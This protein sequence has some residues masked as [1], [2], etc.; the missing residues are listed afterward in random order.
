MTTGPCW[1][2]YS[3]H[4]DTNGYVRVS[5][6]FLKIENDLIPVKEQIYDY[7]IKSN[8]RVLKNPFSINGLYQLI[9]KALVPFACYYYKCVPTISYVKIIKSYT[10]NNPKDTQFF[11]RDP[12]SHK[13][14]KAVIYLNDVDFEGGP[15]VYVQGTNKEDL[16]GHSGRERIN[17]NIVKQRYK[18]KVKELVGPF[19]QVIFFDAMGIHKGK[20]PIQNDRIAIIV[21]FSLHSEYGQKDNYSKVAYNITGDYDDFDLMLLDSCMPIFGVENENKS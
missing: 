6:Q 8:T 9:K 18:N 4:L 15:L 21:N 2:D 19:G 16:V 14:L 12:G 7:Y 3:R 20:L 5:P 10:S 17:D 1:G 11:H 13:L